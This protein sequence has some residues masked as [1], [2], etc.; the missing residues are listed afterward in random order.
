MRTAMGPIGKALLAVTALSVV[1]A[2]PLAAAPGD[3]SV[4]TFLQKANR[5]EKKGPLALLTSDYK[6]LK[7]EIE[8]TANTYKNKLK[9]DRAA[10][11]KTESCPPKGGVSLNSDQ[12]LAHLRSYPVAKRRSTSIRTAFADMMRKRFPCK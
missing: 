8:G 3:M 12:L 7:R 9:R 6:L 2:T 4:A 10:K 1:W 11:R 5:L